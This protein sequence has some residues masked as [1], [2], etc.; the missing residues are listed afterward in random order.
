[1]LICHLLL[2]CE[3]SSCW[4][5]KM[6]WMHCVLRTNDFHKSFLLLL[7]VVRVCKRIITVL[8][9]LLYYMS[10]NYYK[11]CLC[12]SHKYYQENLQS[13]NFLILLLVILKFPA[14]LFL[15]QSTMLS[16]FCVLCI[17]PTNFL[18]RSLHTV[19]KIS[20]YFVFLRELLNFRFLIKIQL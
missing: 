18:D 11:I 8:H 3:I 13:S 6:I 19:W 5:Q 17:L 16:H 9:W 15:C 1:M 12:K 2:C 10:P 20:T 4:S 14:F 7:C